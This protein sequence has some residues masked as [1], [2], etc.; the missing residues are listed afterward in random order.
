M[1]AEVS[2]FLMG[3]VLEYMRATY[4]LGQ[5]IRVPQPSKI[6]WLTILRQVMDDL[7]SA[8]RRIAQQPRRRLIRRQEYVR[9]ERIGSRGR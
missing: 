5:T 7:E 3:L 1:L 6:E 9:A 4:R 2:D 8:F